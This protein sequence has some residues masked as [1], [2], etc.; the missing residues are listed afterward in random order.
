MKFRITTKSLILISMVTIMSNFFHLESLANPVISSVIHPVSIQRYE[1]FEVDFEMT[2]NFTNPYDYSEIDIRA[3]FICTS[4][5]VSDTINGFF[6]QDFTMSFGGPPYYSEEYTPVGNG[7][8]KL[9]YAPREIGNY[10]FRIFAEDADGVTYSSWYNF[11]V[12]ASQLGVNGFLHLNSNEDYMTFD[13]NQLH[14]PINANIVCSFYNPGVPY[15]KTLTEYELWF[16]NFSAN[17]GNT[18]RV[19][20]DLYWG[21]SLDADNTAGNNT[22]IPGHYGIQQYKAYQLDKVF[23]MAKD[24]DLFIKLCLNTGWS[25]DA[26]DSVNGVFVYHNPYV[27]SGMA[28]ASVNDLYLTSDPIWFL[29]G[30]KQRYINA[31]WGYSRNL[32]SWEIFNEVKETKCGGGEMDAVQQALMTDWC[33]AM[34]EY[35]KAI[36]IYDHIITT[37]NIVPDKYQNYVPGEMMYDIMSDSNIDYT[38]THRYNYNVPESGYVYTSNPLPG[39]INSDRLQQLH[40]FSNTEFKSL[41][42]KPTMINE[43]LWHAMSTTTG[44]VHSEEFDPEGVLLRHC[45]WTSYCSGAVGTSSPWNWGQYMEV[46][47]NWWHLDGLSKFV[48]LTKDKLTN[49]MSAKQFDSFK[50]GTFYR[51]TVLSGS[52]ITFGYMQ[53]EKF[54]WENLWLNHNDY[55][56]SKNPVYYPGFNNTSATID[57]VIP[58]SGFE[59][60]W[61]NTSTMAVI[62]TTNVVSDSQGEVTISSPGSTLH[63]DP[64]Y[65][66]L[67]FTLERTGALGRDS[68]KSNENQTISEVFPQPAGDQFTIDF[69]ETGSFQV[70]L[71]DIKGVEKLDKTVSDTSKADFE[72][73]GLPSGV[74]FIYI[75]KNDGSTDFHRLIKK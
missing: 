41:F 50:R 37:S 24:R 58:N 12:T 75:L 56:Y 1:K 15:D 51:W 25:C 71:T 7:I 36:D 35:V 70:V 53:S 33:H 59:L 16:D 40:F 3:E 2:G 11:N 72:I 47:G 20:M 46:K 57:A 44:D 48:D 5:G 14:V 30:N 13:N 68:R 21:F 6:Y 54:D 39:P 69:K 45:I 63:G 34:T 64:V 62:S 28:T 9:R 10:Q 52:D 17:G 38:E 67:A 61:Y 27:S 74:Y 4:H 60:K 32:E 73:S 19:W 22:H 31:R 8:W 65:G 43:F 42:E 26:G 18:A 49:G 55:L 29:R 23:E 66:D